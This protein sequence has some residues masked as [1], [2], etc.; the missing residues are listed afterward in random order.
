MTKKRNKAEKTELEKRLEAAA[1]AEKA[2]QE[3]AGSQPETEE[4]KPAQDEQTSA[5]ADIEALTAEKE[6]LQ[7][8]LLRARAEFENARKR[9]ARETERIRKTAAENVI[10]DLLP[11]LDHLDLALQHA[12]NPDSAFAQGVEMV[13]KQFCEALARH[14]LEPIPATG[15][16]FDPYVHEAM[17]QRAS[18]DVPADVV[19]EEF[20]KGYKLGDSVL[21]PSKVVVSSGPES[22]DS[23]KTDEGGKDTSAPVKTP[24]AEDRATDAKTNETL[25]DM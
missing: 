18:D 14:G 24:A 9:M 20:Q 12:E 19:I 21:R 23:D 6:E 4:A 13:L 2:A 11:V 7:D 3:A 5:G 10:F 15:E 16:A 22:Q 17:M 8:Q 1:A 25:E